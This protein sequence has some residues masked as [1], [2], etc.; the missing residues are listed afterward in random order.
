MYDKKQNRLN[1]ITRNRR[2]NGNVAEISRTSFSV[3]SE[4]ED[5]IVLPPPPAYNVIFKNPAFE[6]DEFDGDNKLPSYDE[7]VAGSK[8]ADDAESRRY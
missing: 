7:V 4:N 8:T 2:S 3:V 1:G 5:G 6:L